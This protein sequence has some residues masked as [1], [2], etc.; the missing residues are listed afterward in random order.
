MRIDGRLID[1]RTMAQAGKLKRLVIGGRRCIQ[2]LG[3]MVV[4]SQLAPSA[5]A[6]IGIGVP[7]PEYYVFCMPDALAERE[8]EKLI[9]RDGWLDVSMLTPGH[10]YWL[11]LSSLG[12]VYLD[13]EDQTEENIW[14][15]RWYWPLPAEL[16]RE[17][18]C[19]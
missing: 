11:E 6:G 7:G 2:A 5:E 4:I 1:L 18:R 16:L 8:Y 13:R 12:G 14:N 10:R 19:G 17:V 9:T 3:D 15:T